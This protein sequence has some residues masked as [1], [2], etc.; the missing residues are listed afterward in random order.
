MREVL[1]PWCPVS[2][3]P[4]W[5]CRGLFLPSCRWFSCPVPTCSCLCFFV[6]P[7][8]SF[9]WPRASR[10]SSGREGR[11]VRLL[12]FSGNGHRPKNRFFQV[13]PLVR[14]PCASQLVHLVLSHPLCVGPLSIYLTSFIYVYLCPR[15]IAS[16]GDGVRPLALIVSLS[17]GLVRKSKR[18][19]PAV[20]L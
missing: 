19:N 16:G 9:F 12:S 13:S 1:R 10:S 7:P 11:R 15:V 20:I 17:T 6:P 3:R 5:P 14:L 8:G 18:T 2:P 4:G